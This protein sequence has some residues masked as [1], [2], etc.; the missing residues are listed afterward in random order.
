MVGAVAVDITTAGRVAGIVAGANLEGELRGRNPIWEIHLKAESKA[1]R[2]AA[3][4]FSD[5]PPQVR[6]TR[7]LLARCLLAVFRQTRMPKC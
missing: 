1:A 2:E 5:E 6:P 7:R 4:L 3:F